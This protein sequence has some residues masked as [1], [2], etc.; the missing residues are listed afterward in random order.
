[1]NDPLRASGKIAVERFTIDSGVMIG[2][3]NSADQDWPPS[4]FVGAYL[5]SFTTVGRHMTPMYGTSAGSTRF[6]GQ[7]WPLLRPDGTV[8]DWAIEYDPSAAGG[9]GA[10]T[11]TLDSVTRTLVLDAG[12]RAEGALMDRFGIFNMQDNNGKHSLIYLDD[13]SYTS[14]IPEPWAMSVLGLLAGMMLRRR[15]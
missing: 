7:P 4:N 5:D 15:R 10:I 9:L 2:W 3:F 6:A 8:M 1:M 11:V 13:I 12:A 14:A